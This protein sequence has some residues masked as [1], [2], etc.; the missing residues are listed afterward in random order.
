[1]HQLQIIIVGCKNRFTGNY[2]LESVGNLQFRIRT[3]LV[4]IDQNFKLQRINRF[5]PFGYI[6]VVHRIAVKVFTRL[7]KL[8]CQIQFIQQTQKNTFLRIVGRIFDTL[9]SLHRLT[10]G[11]IAHAHRKIEEFPYTDKMAKCCIRI[12]CLLVGSKAYHL[13]H[14]SKHGHIFETIIGEV[15]C[16][17]QF[18]EQ[19]IDV[20]SFGPRHILA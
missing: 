2:L 6:S 5:S 9:F 15:V 3:L 4:Q 17:T 10:V 13:L 12:L 20:I 14:I 11:N 8:I 18:I 16:P 7:K 1:M 19:V